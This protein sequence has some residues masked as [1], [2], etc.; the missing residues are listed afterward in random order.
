MISQSSYSSSTANRTDL[1]W[2]YCYPI[3]ENDNNDTVYNFCEKVMKGGITRAKEH[4]MG[5]KGNVFVCPK[6]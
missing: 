2:K 5:Q 3:E 4:L 1:G 6:C